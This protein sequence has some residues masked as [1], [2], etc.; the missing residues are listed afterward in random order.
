MSRSTYPLKGFHE[1]HGDYAKEVVTDHLNYVNEEIKVRCEVLGVEEKDEVIFSYKAP[2][3]SPLT[4]ETQL[5]RLAHH[6]KTMLEILG[7]MA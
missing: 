2:A 1:S 3:D 6:R 4:Y 7:R 5:E